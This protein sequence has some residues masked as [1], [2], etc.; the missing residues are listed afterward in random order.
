VAQQQGL[1][2]QQ[3][4]GELQK[5]QLREAGHV[6]DNQFKLQLEK[7]RTEAQVAAAEINTKAQNLAE[8]MAFVEDL[9]H[10]FLDQAHEV[11][12]AAHD[13]A[14]DRQAAT[15]DQA[16]QAGLAAQQ[17]AAAQQQQP[18]EPAD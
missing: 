11:G 17:Q 12:M 13:A 6:I 9:A 5:L 18:S 4:Q 10:K 8:R 14:T 2:L 1:L 15:Q 7:M 16:H 3:L